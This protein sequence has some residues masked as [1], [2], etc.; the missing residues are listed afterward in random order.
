[1]AIQYFGTFPTVEYTLT[2]DPTDA[3]TVVDIT[4]RV[5]IRNDFSEYISSYYKHV[6]TDGRR[7]ELYA[8]SAYGSILDH[9]ILLHVNGVVDPYFD[10]VLD[11]A[12]F[13]AYMQKKYPDEVLIYDITTI[14]PDGKFFIIGETI[15]G[16][17]SGDTATVKD[18]NP[19][20]GQIVY[21]NGP[22]WKTS[23]KTFDGV[24]DVDPSTDRI[25][26]TGHGLVTNNLV[27]YTTGVDI[28]EG[29]TSGTTYYAIRIDDDTLSL[30]L[31]LSGSVIALTADGGS[32]NHLLT[33]I[34]VI[35]GSE[36]GASATFESTVKEYAAPK[37]Y[38]V[39]RDNGDGSE[40]RLNV[41]RGFSDAERAKLPGGISSWVAPVA[42]DNATYEYRLN[43]ENREV[44][45]L[46][47]GLIE[48]FE[49]DFKD[50]IQ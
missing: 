6:V 8:L 41:S 42:I 38:E 19:D 5:G 46:N 31:T 44:K 9:W 28:V 3:K 10:W 47:P 16:S 21:T 32:G 43:E 39:V 29:L 25:T 30:S 22:D 26:V 24:D 1:M 17:P 15:T 13:D 37:F 11:Y 33:P 40:D 18:S 49:E 36:S 48:S 35:T 2:K 4:K 50:K 14:S 20:L 27:V 23:A 12:K 7:P 34:D 45:M